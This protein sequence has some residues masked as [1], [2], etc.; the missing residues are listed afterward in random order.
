M[1]N[2]IIA[3]AVLICFAVP[4][5]AADLNAVSGTYVSQRDDTKFLMLRPDATFVLKQRKDPPD[6]DHPFVEFTGKYEISG[7]KLKLIL[8]DGGTAEG[9]LSGNM[10]TDS[11]GEEWVRK[12]ATPKNV[13]RPK[14]K[15]YWRQ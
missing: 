15:P 13:E 11:Q 5:V 9:K 8:A 4:A 2:M 3:I 7:E 12:P 10:F 1:K 14:P 6:R